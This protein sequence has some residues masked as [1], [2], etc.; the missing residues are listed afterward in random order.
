MHA[1]RPLEIEL[2]AV[3][4]N[5]D[6]EAVNLAERCD[7]TCAVLSVE[8]QGHPRACDLVLVSRRPAAGWIARALIHPA[9][10]ADVASVTL[11]SIS[12]EGRQ[13]PC[14]CL[15]ATVRVGYN[16]QPAS[17]GAVYAAAEEENL[18]A[19]QAALDAGGSTEEADEVREWGNGTVG[20]TRNR[21]H[22]G[23]VLYD[24][25]L[26]FQDGWTSVQRSA[27]FGNFECIRT[28]LGAGADPAC[29]NTAS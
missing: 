5:A 3:E 6:A 1:N 13:L 14:D 16:H 29:P 2:A 4:H 17:V 7:S 19:L 12:M 8:I 27:L 23:G 21:L 20:E 24:T 18:P 22:F 11:V 28:L 9:A 15:P 10:F 26:I 25:G